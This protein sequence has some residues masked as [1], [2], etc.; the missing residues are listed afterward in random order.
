MEAGSVCINDALVHYFC[1]ESPFGGVK[2]SGLGHRHGPEALR[3]FTRTELIV[4]DRPGLGAIGRL[5]R[6][7]LG[8]PY[9]TPVARL[10]RWLKLRLYG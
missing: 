7:Q 1:V 10:F 2:Q 4:E 8:Y 6:R 9:R 5:A 3:Q